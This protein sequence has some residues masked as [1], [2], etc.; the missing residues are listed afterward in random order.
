MNMGSERLA[1]MLGMSVQQMEEDVRAFWSGLVVTDAMEM[2][3]VGDMWSRI[4]ATG[5]A[6]LFS[7]SSKKGG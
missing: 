4:Q 7:A 6:A 3:R 5:R 2:R 1:K